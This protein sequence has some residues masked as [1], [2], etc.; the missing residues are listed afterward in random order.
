MVEQISSRVVYTNPWMTIREDEI[1][2]ADGAPGIY[3]YIERAD[4]VL[5]I[6]EENDGFHLVE[7]YRHPIR[8]R[9]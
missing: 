7:E 9:S 4:F 5:V 6:P 1:V 2:H 8:R 3:G